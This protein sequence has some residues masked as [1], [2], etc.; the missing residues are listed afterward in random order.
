MQQKNNK[1]S[2]NKNNFL[3]AYINKGLNIA[4]HDRIQKRF[5]AFLF[6]FLWSLYIYEK[7]GNARPW[8]ANDQTCVYAISREP[9]KRDLS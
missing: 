5:F 1:V 4:N 7:D 2:E 8:R 6:L 9:L 3:R